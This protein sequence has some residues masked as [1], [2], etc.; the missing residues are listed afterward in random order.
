MIA[1]DT[2][3]YLSID[4][5]G[6]LGDASSMWQ[7]DFAMGTVTHQNIGFLWPTAPFFALGDLLSIPDW[8]VQRLWLGSLLF[9]AGLGVLWFLRTIGWRGSPVLIAA[10]GYML[11]PYILDYVARISVILLPWAGL[12]WMLG[13]TVRSLRVAGWRYPALFAL[14]VLTVGGVNATSLLLVGLGPIL[15]IIWSL[16]DGSVEK[17]VA[18]KAGFRIAL[19][20][21]A[22]SIWW[23]CGLYI[24]AKYGLPTL[25]LTET[26]EVVS[27]ATTAPELFRGLGYWFFYGQDKLGPWIEPANSYTRWALP[28]S[29]AL[30]LL[31]LLAAALTRF[32]YR[33]HFIALFSIGMLV[34]IG[35]HPF[36]GPSPLGRIFKEWTTTDTGLAMRS[37]PRALPLVVLAVAI[38][39][40]AGVGALGSAL[41]SWRISAAALLLLAI[42]ANCSPLWRGQL[43]GNNLQR[44]EELPSYWH[45]LAARINQSNPHESRVLELPG[46]DFAAHRWG[47][48]VD[49]ILPGLIDRGHVARELVPLG[50]PPSA[51]LLVAIDTEIQEGRFDPES[52]A[53]LA[54]IMGVGDV[55]FRGDLQYE[56]YRTP[57]P[58]DLWSDLLEAPGFQQALTYGSGAPNRPFPQRPLLDEHTL[59]RSPSAPEP[60]YAAIFTLED[61]QKIHRAADPKSPIILVGDS[62][63]LVTAAGEGFLE[64]GRPVFFA[65]TLADNP[66]IADQSGALLL[67]TD[68]NRK[69]AQRWG[70][71]RETQG[72]TERLDEISLAYDPSDQRLEAFE[73]QLK[74]QTVAV[75]SEILSS[76]TSYGNPVTLTPDSRPFHAVDGDESTAWKTA[77]FSDA[78]NERLFLE[79]PDSVLLSSVELQQYI[80]SSQNRDIQRIQIRT[81][82][83]KA[84]V[85]LDERS[86]PPNYQ[87][88]DL[89]TGMTDFLEIT[90]LQTSDQGR[91]W[92][93]DSSSV[94]FA[95]IRHSRFVADET[96]VL[97]S[98]LQELLKSDRGQEIA[99]ILRRLRSDPLDPIR[100][101]GETHLDRTFQLP[102][103]R[104]F[105][106]EGEI[107]LSSAASPQLLELALDRSPQPLLVSSSRLAGSLK[108]EAYSA[109][110]GDRDTAWITAFG[111]QDGQSLK[112]RYENPEQIG[113]LKIL[114][115]TGEK[116]STPQTVSVYAD[117]QLLENPSLSSPA[118]T[119]MVFDFQVDRAVSNLEIIFDDVEEKL[120]LD[121]YNSHP[122]VLPVAISEIFGLPR[123][124][125]LP[126]LDPRCR[127]DL[128]NLDGEKIPIRLLGS[129]ADAIAQESIPFESCVGQL[130]LVAGEH[131][132]ISA[133]P[134]TTGFNID[135]IVLRSLPDLLG[136]KTQSALPV[137]QVTERGATKRRVSI[138]SNGEPFWLVLA[139]SYS[140]GW[141]LSSEF[142]ASDTRP[143]LIDA[144]ANGWLIDPKGRSG[145]IVASLEWTP[146]RLV[147][148]GLSTTLLSVLLCLVLAKR[149][150]RCEKEKRA[151]VVLVN[152]TGRKKIF[153][154]RTALLLGALVTILAWLNLPSWPFAAP[155]L[156]C[157]TAATLSGRIWHRVLPLLAFISM[158]IAALLIA[159]D[160]IR[161]RYPRDFLWPSFFDRYHVLGVFAVL[162][163][164][165]EAFRILSDARRSEEQISNGRQSQ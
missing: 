88:V 53:S 146:Q 156:G 92:Y 7:P 97:S 21:T 17:S 143:H 56:R 24:Q 87:S 78:K 8:I 155:L 137:V 122:V 31:G 84:T 75:H 23:I 13:L 9:A 59:D 36:L 39:L 126:D 110:D 151:S 83:G 77:A 57:R 163:C 103:S 41:P 161:F 101:D 115:R 80:S 86:Y 38:F 69:R 50:T 64:P 30:P 149:G 82:N 133:S 153:E 4:P 46:S 65:A 148:F 128:L 44:P 5:W 124:P 32:R 35:S 48:S 162:C 105:G 76:A 79:Y 19:L 121:W 144:Y 71:I 25:R 113:R 104:S 125:V 74:N 108:S 93:F 129:T 165:A 43:L 90:I 62:E 72:Y 106:I 141:K 73:G 61:I 117:D 29:F 142:L 26:Y 132:M 116:Y 27:Q 131:R 123:S 140:R 95:E 96:I 127:D 159:V 91:S 135:K 34:A 89:P 138:H 12:P 11:S 68:S 85:D 55:I 154:L 40:A 45:D 120:T 70:T 102:F 100:G 118:S 130:D 28:L 58:S 99:V 16:A 158:S 49:P 66:E 67:L 63:G 134:H 60:P 107:R 164:L 160:Q 81:A 47:N 20:S 114:A 109:L 37:T 10:A 98:E 18:L 157:F 33:G 1:A 3:A 112:V 2:K 147:K 22:T 94:G 139:E 42:V 150:R 54:Q 52:L 145:E 136:S 111:E 15:W 119:S 6:L 14:V 152:P 51:A